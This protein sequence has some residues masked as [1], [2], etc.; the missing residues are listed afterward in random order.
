MCLGQEYTGLTDK[1]TNPV[2]PLDYLSSI[3]LPRLPSNIG[4]HQASHY[5]RACRPHICAEIDSEGFSDSGR[6]TPD[7]CGIEPGEWMFKKALDEIAQA[8][9][10]ITSFVNKCRNGAERQDEISALPEKEINDMLKSRLGIIKHFKAIRCMARDAEGKCCK[11]SAR[12]LEGS[13]PSLEPWILGEAGNHSDEEDSGA[14]HQHNHIEDHS[15]TDT[16][17][18]NAN[19]S[20]EICGGL[21]YDGVA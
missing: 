13:P 14:P 9:S 10:A 12:R 19:N 16:K 7:A 15:R 3:L 6:E 5:L 8:S 11:E 4:Y 21:K 2:I 1:A 18:D 17:N 20:V